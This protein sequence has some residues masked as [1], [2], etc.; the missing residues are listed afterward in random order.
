[1]KAAEAG[2]DSCVEAVALA[3]GDTSVGT[4]GLKA[5]G[6]GVVVVELLLCGDFATWGVLVPSGGGGGND[7]WVVE[8]FACLQPVNTSKKLVKSMILSLPI[9]KP[10]SALCD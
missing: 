10:D 6:G 1:M 4:A 5:V 9:L 7:S 3:V 2:G 8:I